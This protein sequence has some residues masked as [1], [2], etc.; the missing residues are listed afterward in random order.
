MP[1][2]LPW[3]LLIVHLKQPKHLLP[4]PFLPGPPH[5]MYC[6]TGVRTWAILGV[7]LSS[8][9]SSHSRSAQ[10][11]PNPQPLPWSMPILSQPDPAP[12]SSLVSGLTLP[13][14][15]HIQPRDLLK[16]TELPATLLRTL[17]ES[18]VPSGQSPGLHGSSRPLVVCPV[19]LPGP[20]TPLTIWTQPLCA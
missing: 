7:H 17:P 8:P 15:L 3:D 14:S 13:S 19:H 4:N 10:I 11:P 12:A 5:L 6:I 18:P 20:R 9:T 2:D 16:Q 1:L